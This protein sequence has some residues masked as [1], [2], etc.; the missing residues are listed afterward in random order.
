MK[1]FDA[2]V[3]WD[4]LATEESPNWPVICIDFN[5]V[6]D[7]FK[8][9]NGQVQDYPPAPGLEAFLLALRADF[10][11][12]VVCSATMPIQQVENWF[13]KHGLDLLID[14]V[15]NHKPVAAVYVDDKAVTHRGNF[16]ETLER[17][18]VFKP[19]WST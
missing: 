19:H 1:P 6:C 12:I 14:Y 4:S 7:Q 2:Q 17:I 11:T 18:K 8:G 15:T 5:G 9:W 10:N 3:F 16:E 13:I